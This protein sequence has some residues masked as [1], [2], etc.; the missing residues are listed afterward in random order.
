MFREEYNKLYNSI[1]YPD[2]TP[3]TQEQKDKYNGQLKKAKRGSRI[4]TMILIILALLT[5]LLLDGKDKIAE[6]MGY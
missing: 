4:R 5:L 6:I 1:L 3:M 2:Q